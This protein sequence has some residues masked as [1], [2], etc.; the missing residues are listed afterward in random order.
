MWRA[1]QSVHEPQWDVVS[2]LAWRSFHRSADTVWPSIGR[3]FRPVNWRRCGSRK[4]C[5]LVSGSGGRLVTGDRVCVAKGVRVDISAER[6][7]TDPLWYGGCC[8]LL[9]GPVG[10]LMDVF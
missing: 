3:S 6:C 1:W 4:Q 5:G 7:R 8:V 9:S 10:W 2:V